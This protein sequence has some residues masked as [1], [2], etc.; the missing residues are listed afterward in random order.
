MKTKTNSRKIRIIS[1]DAKEMSSR[2][3]DVWKDTL[4]EFGI[5]VYDHPAFAETDTYGLI[6]SNET[7]TQKDIREISG[8]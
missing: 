5:A 6:L 3:I 7:L 8:F 4:G 1:F 2:A